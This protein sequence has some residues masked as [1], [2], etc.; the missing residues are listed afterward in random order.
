MRPDDWIYQLHKQIYRLRRRRIAGRVDRLYQEIVA[1]LD[2]A[3][4]AERFR[5]FWNPFPDV[6]PAKFL[7]LNVWFREAIY[8]YF[9]TGVP[10]HGRNLRV[11]D[12]GSG[13]GYFSVVCRHQGHEALGLDLDHEP[14]YNECFDFF[15]LPRIV[16][17][18]EPGR[19][20]PEL[21]GRFDVV[22]AFMTCFNW[23]DDGRAWGGEEWTY[24]LGDLRGRLADGGRVIVRFNVHP[25]TGEFYSADVRRAIVACRGYRAKF[26]LHYVFLSAV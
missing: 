9:L 15:A 10:E 18:I 4:F 20:L 16:H 14:L 26:F 25:P 24:F 13:T 19:P 1:G 2:H 8:R 6:G 3:A 7:D 23:Y 21:P 22:T 11:L 5:R 12:L 17:R